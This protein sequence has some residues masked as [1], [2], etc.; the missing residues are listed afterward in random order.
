[1]KV[2]SLLENT[3]TRSDMRT[4]H[5]LSLYIETG[6]HKI[7]FD[8]GQSDAFAAN[9][10]TLGVD[11]RAVGLAVLSHGHYDHGGG[12]AAFL[13]RNSSA[14]VYLSRYAFEPHYH[15][16]GRYIGLNPALRGS[17]QLH[18]TEGETWLGEGLTLC[19][20]N[21]NTRER[22]L[23]SCGLQM[24]QRGSF[25]SNQ[26]DGSAQPAPQMVQPEDSPERNPGGS[27]QGDLAAGSQGIPDGCA[28]TLV[29]EDFRHEQ[30]LLVEE[31]SRRVL[32]SGCS[33]KGILEIVRWFRPD[34]LVGGFHFSG[35]PLDDTLAGYAAALDGYPAEYYTCHCTG[36]A[37]FQFMQQ[38]MK[39]LHYLSCGQTVGI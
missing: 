7:L 35:L 26:S 29:P 32:F 13:E 36:S 22:P 8:M 30:Y 38:Y 1:M 33:H 11:L 25:G 28:C 34:V 20:C 27:L 5:G 23:D 6:K 9:A 19:D 3:S 24:A 15:G 12:L 31:H 14:P 4:E 17:A 21:Q 2:V 10:D 39:R 18:F 37:Q 16:E